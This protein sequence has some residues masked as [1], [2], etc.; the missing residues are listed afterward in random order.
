MTGTSE[1]PI[2]VKPYPGEQPVIDGCITINGAYTHWRDDIEVLDSHWMDR[3]VAETPPVTGFVIAGAVGTHIINN[4]IHDTRYGIKGTNTPGCVVYGNV[5]GNTGYYNTATESYAGHAI[6]AGNLSEL[7][8]IYKHNFIYGGFFVGFHMYSDRAN[9]LNEIQIV[10]NVCFETGT[11]WDTDKYN[12][13]GILIGGFGE[14]V[15]LNPVATGNWVYIKDR[16]LADWHYS[17]DIGYDAGCINPTVTGN[18]MCD[19]GY[20]VNTL[21]GHEGTVADNTLTE[22]GSYPET[23]TEIYLQA[24][25]Y[26][27]NRTHLAI[28]NWALADTVAVD[29]S[30]VFV[31]GDTIQ[32]K[33]VQNYRTDIQELTVSEAGVLTV[34]MQAANRTV[35]TPTAWTAPATIYPQFGAFVL[36]KV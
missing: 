1:N 25:E 10:E 31:A 26:D 8:S 28:L 7:P 6:Y 15:A 27:E 23:G 9:E 2:A 5:I 24:N 35:A 17:I 22:F 3:E 14:C 16:P 18:R 12:N 4:Y 29:V 11:L 13:V 30:S 36:V 19:N 20:R 33:N 34:N 21:E 32:V